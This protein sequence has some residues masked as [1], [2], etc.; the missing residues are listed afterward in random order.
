M[1][2]WDFS[3][4]AELRE[5]LIDLLADALVAY[6]ERAEAEAATGATPG[7]NARETE[8]ARSGE[9]L[10]GAPQGQPQPSA[11]VGRRPARPTGGQEIATP[12]GAGAPTRAIASRGAISCGSRG[13]RRE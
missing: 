5:S 11:R 9:G 4:A 8:E 3:Q 1:T 6:A 12:A 2:A 10:C 13:E 7:G